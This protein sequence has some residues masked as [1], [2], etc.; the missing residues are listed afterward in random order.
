M[1]RVNGK[2]IHIGYYKNKLNAIQARKKAEM[3]YFGEYARIL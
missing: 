2:L 3:N 1:I